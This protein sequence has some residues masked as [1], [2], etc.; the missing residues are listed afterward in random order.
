MLVYSGKTGCVNLTKMERLLAGYGIGELVSPPW[1]PPPFRRP[2]A[3]DNGAWAAFSQE[4]PWNEARFLA[5]YELALQV[6]DPP[7]FVVCP[8]IVQG[9]L[10]SLAFSLGWQRRLAGGPPLYLAVQD[11]M[12]ELAVA[13]HL[14]LFAGI[15][16]G[17]SNGWK[18]KTGERW[19]RL[20]HQLGKRCH[21][22]RAGTPKKAAWAK[23]IGADSIDSTQPLWGYAIL[24]KF[25]RTLEG[26]QGELFGGD[27]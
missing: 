6:P 11:G 8:D 13:P 22:G 24:E 12:S 23:R 1:R 2:W 16:V 10:D 9:G 15:F 21:V 4:E 20:A 25:M 18:V 3:L 14:E 17:G 5:D 26:R 27:L 7:D 19:V